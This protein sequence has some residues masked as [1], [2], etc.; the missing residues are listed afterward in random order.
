MEPESFGINQ[1]GQYF[2]P[3]EAVFLRFAGVSHPSSSSSSESNSPPVMAAIL[4]MLHAHTCLVDCRS[5]MA[6]EMELFS[7][8]DLSDGDL[9]DS[10]ILAPNSEEGKV[11]LHL[12]AKLSAD[13][14]MKETTTNS[15]FVVET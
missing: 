15:L 1:C 14:W 10:E 9:C 12:L 5:I 11:E 2:L 7:S 8:G 3:G 13:V 4:G 6:E